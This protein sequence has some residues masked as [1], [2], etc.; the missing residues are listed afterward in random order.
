MGKAFCFARFFHVS[1]NGILIL[2][3]QNVPHK[4]FFFY[5]ITLFHKILFQTK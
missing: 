5:L 4:E 2:F 3:R 1:L